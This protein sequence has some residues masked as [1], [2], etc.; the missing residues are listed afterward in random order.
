[1][2]TEYT[3]PDAAARATAPAAGDP[4][5]QTITASD[6]E[7][8]SIS[9]GP[10]H[11]STHGVLRLQLELDGEIVTKCD[12]VIGYL[13]RGDEKIA[14]NMTY[15]QFV[16]YT[17]RLDY[18][19]PLANNVAY[20][21][22]VE[23]I[24]GLEV[25]AR[26]QAIR[27]IVAELARISSHLLGFGSFAMDTGSWTAFMYQFNEREKLYKL[28]EELT[29]ARFTT[30][31][32]R[33]GGVARDVPEGWI[34]RV[35]A[36]CDQFLP[37]LEEMLGLLTRNRIF[38]DRT[39]GVGVISREDA[40]SYGLTGP[41]L[42]GSGV[43]FDIRKD[44]PYC[45]YENY[46]FDVPVGT[47]GD[48]Y[49]RY[50]CR[51]E[52][53]RQSVRIVKQAIKNFPGGAWHAG[54]TE[55]ARRI[56]APR[57]DKVLTSM[58]ELINNFMLVTEG[59]QMPPGEVYFEAENPK[60]ALGFYIVSKGGGVPWRMKIRSPSFCTLS[61]MP[62]VGVGCLFTDLTAILGSFDF[63]MGEADR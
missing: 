28:F 38:I 2:S 21:I 40:L 61:I 37:L 46:E 43:P 8:M 18:L 19:A 47:K 63:V 27:V 3:F 25:P 5:F 17:D 41:N 22:A 58:E 14:E 7:K 49:D 55:A 34:Q 44:K 54:G 35:D 51:G 32:T 48:S 13:H 9:M 23:K 52:E 62:K 30:S 31:Y 20:A 53:M 29:G 57:K 15:N 11:P 26:C 50:L 6:D 39:E 16:P 45:G 12:P 56:Y 33:I 36:F 4:L 10:S 60:G 59:P 1:M 24:A 42:R